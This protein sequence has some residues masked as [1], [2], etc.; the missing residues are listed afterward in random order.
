MVEALISAGFL[1]Q[2]QATAFPI[3]VYGLFIVVY[4]I[5]IWT[6]Y[7][8]LGQR[9]IFYAEIE[10]GNS[11]GA[12]LRNTIR[13]FSLVLDY[14]VVL[15]LVSV[16]WFA[17]LSFFMILFAKNQG[18]DTVLTISV[19]LIF[20]T[21]I[22]AYYNEDL[23]KDLAKLIP[24][25]LLGVFLSDPSFFSLDLA[26]KQLYSIPR[27]FPQVMSSVILIIVLEWVLRVIYKVKTVFLGV[28]QDSIH[29]EVEEV[30]EEKIEETIDKKLDEKI[31]QKIEKK[32]R[33]I[34]K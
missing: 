20:A 21:R 31:E 33:E 11:I 34:K 24:F 12:K 15:P 26:V 5:I 16:V 32:I 23:A 4:G 17:I 28:T 27:Y 19:G 6:F 13:N 7:K 14:I 22:A 8:S 10:K 3:V 9:D 30:M 18:V 2:L 29:D 1:E 25:G